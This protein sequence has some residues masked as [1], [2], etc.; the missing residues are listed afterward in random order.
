M[1]SAPSEH[2]H[3]SKSSGM[4]ITSN[5]I[6]IMQDQ[7]KVLVQAN[8]Q[9]HQMIGELMGEVQCIRHE[10]S[11]A[12]VNSQWL[13]LAEACKYIKVGKTTMMK[14]LADGDFPTAVKKGGKWMFKITDLNQYLSQ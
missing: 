9:L 10:M 6:L 3:L 2:G 8:R 4:E 11:S 7:M 14:R 13:E 12:K 1:I 5:D